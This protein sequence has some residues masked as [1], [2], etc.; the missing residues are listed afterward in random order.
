MGVPWCLEIPQWRVGGR[1]VWLGG[2]MVGR[3]R[4]L[5]E[6]VSKNLRG[7]EGRSN[8]RRSIRCG[9]KERFKEQVL[10]IF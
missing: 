3:G 9:G 10:E 1:K 5:K 4:G 7:L 2:Q 8:K 6:D